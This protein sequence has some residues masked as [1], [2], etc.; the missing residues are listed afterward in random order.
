VTWY[1]LSLLVRRSS[2]TMLNNICT[3]QDIERFVREIEHDYQHTKGLILSE[4]DAQCLLYAKISTHLT[5]VHHSSIETAD[6]DV[7]ASPLHTEINFL[8]VNDVLLIRPDITLLDVQNISLKQINPNR[9]VKRKGFEFWGS[10]VVIELKFCKYLAGITQ[11][12]T[13][14]VRRDCEK[15][16]ELHRRLYPPNQDATLSGLVIVF[17]RSNRQCDSFSQLINDYSNNP[18]VRIIYATSNL[19]QPLTSRSSG[20][21]HRA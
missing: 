8:D 17:S 21:R 19:N 14:S 13:D 1:D 18:V 5:M 12:F 3:P 16:E 2:T 20:R 10:A 11:K 9:L 6:S 15:I 7:W 4:H